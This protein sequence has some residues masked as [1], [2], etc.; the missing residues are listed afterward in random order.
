MHNRNTKCRAVE[1]IGSSICLFL[2]EKS[3]SVNRHSQLD[4]HDKL[5]GVIDRLLCKKVKKKQ[6]SQILFKFLLNAHQQSYMS[7]LRGCE[8]VLLHVRS[9]ISHSQHYP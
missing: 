3:A 5:S 8:L 7:T 4:L 9:P 6:N 2:T 1:C